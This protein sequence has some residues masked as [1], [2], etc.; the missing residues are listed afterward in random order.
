VKRRDF[1]TVLSAAAASW[2]L[3]ARAQQPMPV[4]G[5]LDLR[6]PEGM[7]GRL[8]GFRQGLGETGYVE[9][10]NVGSPTAGEKTKSKNVSHMF[11]RF[12]LDPN[13]AISEPG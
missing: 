8:R 11:G 6:L 10:D 9:G 2:P 3:A 5:F 12:N 1:I 13:S 4:V 7:T